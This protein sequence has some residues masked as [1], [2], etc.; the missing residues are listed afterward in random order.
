M[1][2]QTGGPLPLKRCSPQFDGSQAPSP[3]AHVTLPAPPPFLSPD[4][5]GLVVRSDP[6][7][8][9]WDLFPAFVFFKF[10][11]Q[12]FRSQQHLALPETPHPHSPPQ[13]SAGTP[14]RPLTPVPT[15]WGSPASGEG[16]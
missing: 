2:Q 1:T 7:P 8:F 4:S 13:V 16:Q 15:T 9:P 12:V 11:H 10:I 6:G 14:S 3:S 5:P